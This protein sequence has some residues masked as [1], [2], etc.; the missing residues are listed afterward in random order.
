LIEI[1]CYLRYISIQFS[2][3]LRGEYSLWEKILK[4]KNVSEQGLNTVVVQA[5]YLSIKEEKKAS[6]K[7]TYHDNRS[8]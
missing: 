6:L 5:K 2:E 3:D 8:S 4:A 1:I 7:K